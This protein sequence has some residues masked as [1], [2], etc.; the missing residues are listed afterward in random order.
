[1]NV[2]HSANY[3]KP[4]RSF[5]DAAPFLMF[6]QI[7]SSRP[8]IVC[9]PRYDNQEQGMSPTKQK[10]GAAAGL[11]GRSGA[12]GRG[13]IKKTQEHPC[14]RSSKFLPEPI[15]HGSTR[16]ASP[17]TLAAIVTTSL[18]TT[19]AVRILAPSQK[20]ATNGGGSRLSQD[21]TS[22]DPQGPDDGQKRG[23]NLVLVALT[24]MFDY[25]SQLLII[26]PGCAF[27]SFC[28]IQQF[29]PFF[30]ERIFFFSARI[31]TMDRIFDA[32]TACP[33]P[34]RRSL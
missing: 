28:Q 6:E 17:T 11:K 33:R 9:F 27:V 14:C 13:T 12:G 5:F 7:A 22:P 1:M 23:E 18:R 15:S 2:C 30:S 32:R 20:L 8:T 16:Q 34:D 24:D 25:P 26:G 10:S 19:A 3:P 4:P 29:H 31:H 21:N